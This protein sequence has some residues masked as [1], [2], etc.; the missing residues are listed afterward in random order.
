MQ[1]YFVYI[2]TNR[3]R[4][5][6]YTGMTNDLRRRIWQHKNKLIPGFTKQYNCERLVYSDSFAEVRDAIAAEKRI[7]GWVRWKKIA[8]I[9]QYNPEWKDLSD[10]W[11]D[12]SAPGVLR[13]AQDDS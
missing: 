1:A 8:L 6:L 10:G 2:L 13:Y 12:D 11:F 3:W 5:V 7:K 4:T 9:E